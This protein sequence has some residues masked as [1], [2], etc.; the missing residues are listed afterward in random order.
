MAAKITI[1]AEDGSK[2]ESDTFVAIIVEQEGE[3]HY[4]TVLSSIKHIEPSSKLIIV[5]SMTD[6]TGDILRDILKE[7]GAN[8]LFEEQKDEGTSI[9]KEEPDN[10]DKRVP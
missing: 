7:Y 4:A 10:G 2:V 6:A 3:F 8:L 1:E 9:N 5:A